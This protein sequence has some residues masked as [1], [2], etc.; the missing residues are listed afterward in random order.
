MKLFRNT[1]LGSMVAIVMAFTAT[2]Q[3]SNGWI[4]KFAD[5]SKAFEDKSFQALGTVTEIPVSFGNFVKI[6]GNLS[7]K[8]VEQLSLHPEVLYI[9]P[10]YI[11]TINPIDSDDLNEVIKTV[12]QENIADSEFSR[13]WGLKNTG[14]N[15]GEILRRGKVGQDTN[16]LRA[17]DVTTGSRDI[18]IAVIDTGIDYN[19]PDLKAN[20]WVNP[21]PTAEDVHGYNFAAKTPNPMDGNGHGTHCAG[22]I[23]AGHNAIGIRGVMAN[24]KLMAVKFLTDSGRGETADAIASID[25]AVE[26]GAH[27]LSNSWGG[28]GRS[29][30][31]KEA[32]VRANDAG[33]I[34]VAA[35]GNSRADND[36][37]ASFP[38]NYKVENVISVGAMDSRGSK[39]SFTNYGKESVHVF[40]P[41]VNIYSTVQNGGY[42]SLSGTSMAAPFVTGIIG[43]LVGQE[44]NLST[45]ELRERVVATS[46][47]ESSLTPFAQSGRIDAHRLLSNVRN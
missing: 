30:A 9:E 8:S 42:K 5:G 22:V 37:T 33:V 7:D 19:H 3:E 18:V 39:A 2:A 44:E 40:A 10:N 46:V 43:L 34:F 29:E 47:N 13:Q 26:K 15:S 41:G 23:G 1:L 17:W 38:A 27:I 16:I 32:I 25:Y 24:V 11:Y 6:E 28:G 35:A 4:V 31:L 12:E 45:A 21:D 20:M 14:R 36:S